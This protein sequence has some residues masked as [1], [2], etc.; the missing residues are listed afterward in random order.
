MDKLPLES[1][2]KDARVQV[3]SPVRADRDLIFIVTEV[4]QENGLIYLDDGGYIDTF[5]VDWDGLP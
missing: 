2:V 3:D 5:P 4:D 1:F